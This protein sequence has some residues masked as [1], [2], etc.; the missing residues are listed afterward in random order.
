MRICRLSWRLSE[1]VRRFPLGN[2]RVAEEGAGVRRV[3]A[4]M[5]G[6]RGSVADRDVADQL[7]VRHGVGVCD[8]LGWA[9]ELAGL[10]SPGAGFD[11]QLVEKGVIRDLLETR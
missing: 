4:S 11:C 10:N 8:E 1:P 6:R 9:E 2:L 7:Q 3:G 5:R